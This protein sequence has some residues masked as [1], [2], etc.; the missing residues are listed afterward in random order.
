MKISCSHDNHKIFWFLMI[1]RS[2]DFFVSNLCSM[3]LPKCDLPNT[4]SK[5][6]KTYNTDNLEWDW[7]A[8]G[9]LQET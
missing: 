6:R 4:M 8:V 2:P 1:W 9:T 3:L 5:D 7:E